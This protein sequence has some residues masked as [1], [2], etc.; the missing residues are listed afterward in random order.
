MSPAR[1]PT[2]S[3]GRS[4]PHAFSNARSTSSTEV[5]CPV[6][7]FPVET[8]SSL[9]RRLP[10]L[11][12]A[13]A[14]FTVAEALTNVAKYAAAETVTVDV[15]AAGGSLLVTIADDGVGG[16]EFD[17]GSGLRG[18]LDRV[19]AV[20]GRLDVSSPPGKGTRLSVRLPTKV[21]GSL[22]GH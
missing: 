19:Q 10:R 12:E 21:L 20:G 4:W 8:R 15:R 3:C 9:E 1:R 7:R 5:P 17:R 18:L 22:N 11:V 6:P 13:T 14:Y 2:T 16:A